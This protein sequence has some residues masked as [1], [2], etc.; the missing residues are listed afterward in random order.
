MLRYV[1]H[2][3]VGRFQIIHGRVVE[4][5]VAPDEGLGGGGKFSE[6]EQC[7]SVEGEEVDVAVF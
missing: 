5:A 4:V 6:I 7:C 3:I 1:Q 2:E